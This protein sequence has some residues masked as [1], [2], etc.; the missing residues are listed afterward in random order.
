[1]DRRLVFALLLAGL[2]AGARADTKAAIFDA[3]IASV[4]TLVVG[5]NGNMVA[6]ADLATLSSKLAGGFPAVLTLSTTGG[7]DLSVDPVTT[8]SAPV[9]DAS[10]TTWTPTYSTLGAH[11]ITETGATTT[12]AAPGSSAVSVHLVGTKSGVNRF[13]AGTYQATVTVRCE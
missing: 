4:C 13:A 10:A 6:S 11:N 7:V 2:P 1:M 5:F 9:A 8:V 3:T 12:L